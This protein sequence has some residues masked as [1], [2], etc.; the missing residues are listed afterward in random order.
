MAEKTTEKETEVKEVLFENLAY[1]ITVK[2][3]GWYEVN[4][5]NF[6]GEEKAK[7][8]R[9]KLIEADDVA[10]APDLSD[11]P[12]PGWDRVQE[13][14]TKFRNSI[15]ELPMN[16]THMPD[17]SLNPF[18]DRTYHYGWAAYT[19]KTDVP[20]KRTKFWELVSLDDLKELI[21]KEKCPPHYE[22]LV[23]AE[24]S[25]LVYGDLVLMRQP[26]VYR[27]QQLDERNKAALAAFKATE[28]KNRNAM[29]QAGMREVE[30]PVKNELVIQ[31]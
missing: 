28:D 27:R 17:G 26:R 3:G 31:Y 10:D 5:K 30:S 12:P 16:E 25:Y 14:I 23:R 1:P 24:G 11:L 8:Y 15:L 19:D 7:Q 20:D 21:K 9:V 13:R 22:N 2:P 29:Q 6:R 4:G 18:Y